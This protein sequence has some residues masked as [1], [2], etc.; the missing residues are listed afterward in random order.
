[1]S[2]FYGF[3]QSEGISQGNAL[4]DQVKNMND[5]IRVEN[6]NTINNANNKKSEDE[7]LGIFG[8]A[9]DAFQSGNATSRVF[10]LLHL[11]RQVKKLLHLM[12][13]RL[14]RTMLVIVLNLLLM[15]ERQH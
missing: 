10:K 4:T 2:D 6:E 3:S 1:M 13:L 8:G 15:L 12:L 5:G 11:K 9:K 14:Q 7:E